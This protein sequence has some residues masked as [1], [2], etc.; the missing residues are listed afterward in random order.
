MNVNEL[1]VEARKL[2]KLGWTTMV[3]ARDAHELVKDPVLQDNGGERT[4]IEFNDDPK[5]T[6]E[7]VLALFDRTI[8]RVS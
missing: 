6:Q 4:L 7:D 1:L 3:Y 5:T 8:E 2:L